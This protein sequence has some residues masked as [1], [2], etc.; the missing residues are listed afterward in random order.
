MSKPLLIFDF[1]GTICDSLHAAV[2]VFNMVA[3]K[4]NGGLGIAVTADDIRTSRSPD[5]LIEEL[6]IPEERKRDAERELR[7][8]LTDKMTSLSPFAGMP[9]V[10]RHFHGKGLKMGI[11]T[12]NARNNVDI[13]LQQYD[14]QLFDFVEADVDF[15]CKHE[16]LITMRE[17]GEF[18]D[19]PIWLIEDEVRGVEAARRAGINV[20][21]VTWG[22][23]APEV[24]QEVNPDHL[25]DNPQELL[26]LFVT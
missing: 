17:R 14:L 13:F 20:V 22:F 26:Q 18:G 8:A 25:I 11:L 7:A 4:F 12:S 5:I 19:V 16:R 24:L 21:S 9:E 1:D 3:E 23:H 2:A 10:L 15:L 6:R